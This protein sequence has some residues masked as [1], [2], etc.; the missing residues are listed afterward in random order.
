MVVAFS[1]A[2][3]SVPEHLWWVNNE[4][5]S[6]RVCDVG[7]GR[8]WLSVFEQRHCFTRVFMTVYAGGCIIAHIGESCILMTMTDTAGCVAMSC[9]L[10]R[11]DD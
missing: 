8:V 2:C 7:I 3:I 5:V 9:D 6:A 4:L 1:A 11:M 10:W